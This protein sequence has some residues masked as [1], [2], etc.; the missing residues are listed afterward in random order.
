MLK[1]QNK[2]EFSKCTVNLIPTKYFQS[3]LKMKNSTG[4][5]HWTLS[6]HLIMLIRQ[7]RKWNVH[8]FFK[9]TDAIRHISWTV[10]KHHPSRL[11]VKLQFMQQ[12]PR[13]YL[14]L[15]CSRRFYICI[16]ILKYWHTFTYTHAR[17]HSCSK[18]STRLAIFVKISHRQILIQIRFLP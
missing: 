18:L 1:R 14:K 16:L 11:E 15:I 4:T 17:V 10:S 2:C 7:D 12:N 13:Y 6:G 8:L 3:I 5:S 9:N